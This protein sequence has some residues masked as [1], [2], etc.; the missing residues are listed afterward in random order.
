L[1]DLLSLGQRRL[2]GDLHLGK[3]FGG[4]HPRIPDALKPLGHRM[5]D[6]PADKRLNRDGFVLQPVGAVGDD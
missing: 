1:D 3:R 4:L 2:N 5:L 6:H